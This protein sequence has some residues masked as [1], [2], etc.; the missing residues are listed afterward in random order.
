MNIGEFFLSL[1][2]VRA[3]LNSNLETQTSLQT[4][5]STMK[6]MLYLGSKTPS[7]EEG[8]VPLSVMD[9]KLSSCSGAVACWDLGKHVY[10]TRGEGS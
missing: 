5:Y 3:S 1:M 6:G 7:S 4:E 8:N 9:R 10:F 2:T